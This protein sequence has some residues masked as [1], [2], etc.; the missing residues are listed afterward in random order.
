MAGQTLWCK[1]A[2]SSQ[3]EASGQ[4]LTPSQVCTRNDDGQLPDTK[5]PTFGGPPAMSKS[6]STTTSH[7]LLPAPEP[8]SRGPQHFHLFGSWRRGKEICAVHCRAAAARHRTIRPK[9]T[10][11]RASTYI[12]KPHSLV[13]AMPQGS[14]LAQPASMAAEFAVLSGPVKIAVPTAGDFPGALNEATAKHIYASQGSQT[15]GVL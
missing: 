9:T 15:S 5:L 14:G 13:L 12:K 2:G 4:L 7:P 11:G 3:A 1:K 10:R 8:P 6:V